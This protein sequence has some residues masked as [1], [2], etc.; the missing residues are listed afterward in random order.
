MSIEEGETVEL[1]Q[2]T[3]LEATLR[4]YHALIVVEAAFVIAEMC[5]ERPWRCQTDQSEVESQAAGHLESF[6]ICLTD[7]KSDW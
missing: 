3:L 6:G 1:T 4:K 5:C 7:G 2:V